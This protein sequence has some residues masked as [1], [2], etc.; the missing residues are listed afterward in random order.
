[1]SLKKDLEGVEKSLSFQYKA[2]NPQWD[3]IR[4]LEKQKKD[5]IALKKAVDRFLKR[6]K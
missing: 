5:L 1:V 3:V 2:K 6:S 4:G